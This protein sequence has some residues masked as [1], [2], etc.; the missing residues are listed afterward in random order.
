MRTLIF[1]K[2]KKALHSDSARKGATAS[3][4]AVCREVIFLLI[5]LCLSRDLWG[6]HVDHQRQSTLNAS[7]GQTRKGIGKGRPSPFQFRSF[8]RQRTSGLVSGVLRLPFLPPPALVR[9]AVAMS[10]STWAAALPSAPSTCFR[11]DPK[12]RSKRQPCE[13]LPS[14]TCKATC[15][16]R[17]ERVCFELHTWYTC[18]KYS[19]FLLQCV[20]PLGHTVSLWTDFYYILPPGVLQNREAFSSRGGACKQLA[21]CHATPYRVDL[22]PV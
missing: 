6:T 20:P 3:G 10:T 1:V 4:T 5:A 15:F 16:P 22:P 2:N 14:A 8:C 17:T 9:G 13:Y 18:T 12:K 21:P 11:F 19:V 7:S